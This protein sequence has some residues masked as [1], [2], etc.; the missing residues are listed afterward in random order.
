[1]IDYRA[2]RLHFEG[3][4]LESLALR[5]G[6]PLY[7]YSARQAQARARALQSA[8]PAPR[9]L[10]CYALKA[11]SNPRLCRLM[12]RQG[13]GADI[14]SGGEL[15]VALASGFPAERVLFSGVG[16]TREELRAAVGAGLLSVNLES[17]Q[18]L[19]ALESVAKALKRPAAISV[20]VNPGVAARTHPHIAT[21]ARGSKFG[22]EPAEALSMYDRARRNRWL[23]I[24]GIHCH[25]GSQISDVEDYKSATRAITGLLRTLRG[26]GIEPEL[27]DFGGGLGI[28]EGRDPGID[29]RRLSRLLEREIAPWPRARALIE[30]G[31]YIMAEA[32]ILLTRVLYRK[33]AYGRRFLIVDAGMN[34]LIRPALYG[35][36]HPIWP[37][38][39]GRDSARFDVAGP[40]CESADF[41]ARDY[42]LPA[43]TEAGHTLAILQAG[44]YGFSMASRYNSR[45]LPAEVLL[46]DGRPRLI[47]RRL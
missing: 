20:R 11:N 31:R 22:V 43:A 14:V 40:V 7:V 24:A 27:I 37:A 12:A 10:V 38:R 46:Q 44:A 34:D 21:G 8:F 39:R 30:P 1:M 9:W 6:T 17:S 35:A 5:W 41:F 2:G 19:E 23:R 33:Q 36:R 26:R 16:K 15:E 13:L 3:V 18:E 25:I 42:P 4:P 29:P 32:G 45:S 28:G 47:R